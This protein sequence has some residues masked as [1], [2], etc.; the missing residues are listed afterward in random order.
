MQIYLRTPSSLHLARQIRPSHPF[1]SSHGS[2]TMAIHVRH[3]K[4]VCYY[5]GISLVLTCWAL[6]SSRPGK[7]IPH[8]AA[9]VDLQHAAR[10]LLLNSVLAISAASLLFCSTGFA[11]AG[12]LV[13]NQRQGKENEGL[14]YLDSLPPEAQLARHCREQAA[15]TL[16]AANWTVAALWLAFGYSLE[17]L[18]WVSKLSKPQTEGSMHAVQPPIAHDGTA[19]RPGLRYTACSCILACQLP[20]GDLRKGVR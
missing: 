3:A 12:L 19:K 20:G 11:L 1:I 9:A 18:R 17:S 13:F 16:T 15:Q 14:H 4:L 5:V 7:A 2:L 10:F 8:P 6:S